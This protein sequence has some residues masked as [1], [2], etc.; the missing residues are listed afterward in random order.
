MQYRTHCLT[1]CPSRLELGYVSRRVAHSVKQVFSTVLIL[2][3]VTSVGCEKHS[4]SKSTEQ[5]TDVRSTEVGRVQLSQTQRHNL[6]IYTSV[7]KV[8]SFTPIEE[9]YG[10][11]IPNPN[12]TYETTAPSAGQLLTGNEGLPK[13]GQFVKQGQM[14][15][16]LKVRVS[17]ELRSDFE[18]RIVEAESRLK[19]DEEVVAS[20]TKIK[21]G[22]ERIAGQ[23]I[24]SR[25]ELESATANV[26]RAQSQL[27]I[28]KSNIK[29]WTSVLSAIK[30]EKS[31]QDDAWHLPILAPHDGTVSELTTNSGAFVEPGTLLLRLVDHTHQ[32]VQLTVRSQRGVMLDLAQA[33]QNL[34][35]HIQSKSYD[36]EF[37]GVASAI[38]MSSQS[39]QWLY[40][41]KSYSDALRPG[42]LVVAKYPQGAVFADA[43]QIPTSCV[44]QHK[45][46]QFVYVDKGEGAFERRSVQILGN[47]DANTVV[48]PA[49]EAHED[50]A[51][52]INTDEEVVS[53]GAQT[54]LSREFLVAAGDDD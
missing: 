15:G 10:R 20:L 8:V 3:I 9:V 29:N 31:D 34:I 53:E 1:T 41:I 28:D 19:S 17:P 5:N 39:M 38:D 13:P 49:N 22:L 35:V 46:L 33:N 6:G 37:I 11:V 43:I 32:I 14:I 24:L 40:S 47:I 52:G 25:T 7:A 21:E 27:A 12:A 44:I 30:A 51:I 48:R 4:D 26:A 23:E 42:L 50:S 54:L 18:N 36:A 45:G 2:T 16:S